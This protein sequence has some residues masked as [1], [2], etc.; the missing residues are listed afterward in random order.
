MAD[1]STTENES[2]PPSIW[3]R[4][5]TR[6]QA[7]KAGGALVGVAAAA[8]ATGDQ[9][10]SPEVKQNLA[11]RVIDRFVSLVRGSDL[12]DRSTVKKPSDAEKKAILAKLQDP[13]PAPTPTSGPTS[14]P[15]KSFEAASKGIGDLAKS[16]D[17]ALS[18]PINNPAGKPPVPTLTK[19][20]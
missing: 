20:R 13:A 4:P 2:V 19:P 15:V 18:L 10:I 9:I 5:I 12:R 1:A 7:L 8:V 17:N 3:D 14:E 6:R 11:Q 16:V